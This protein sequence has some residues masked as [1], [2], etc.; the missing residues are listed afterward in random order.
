MARTRALPTDLCHLR[1]SPQDFRSNV[2]P[3]SV[4]FSSQ[5]P[6]VPAAA[7]RD[8]KGAAGQESDPFKR[9][10]TALLKAHDWLQASKGPLA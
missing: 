7:G 8:I 10:S 4:Q 6:P 1:G 9:N 5:F 3:I 2:S